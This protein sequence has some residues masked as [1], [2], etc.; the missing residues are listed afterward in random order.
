MNCVHFQLAMLAYNLNCW[1]M[2]FNRVKTDPEG[3]EHH[4]KLGQGSQGPGSDGSSRGRSGQ[5]RIPFSPSAVAA[6]SR[7]AGEKGSAR[8]IPTAVITPSD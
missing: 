5:S 1:L 3:Q 2:Q 6:A 4:S 7:K 8:S